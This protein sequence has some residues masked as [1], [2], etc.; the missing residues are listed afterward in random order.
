MTDM[1][2]KVDHTTYKALLTFAT[3]RPSTSI[4]Y[5]LSCRPLLGSRALS[6]RL[7]V[8]DVT[9]HLQLFSEFSLPDNYV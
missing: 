8:S 3:T 1:P 9:I 6:F 4:V 7:H 2:G 5:Y